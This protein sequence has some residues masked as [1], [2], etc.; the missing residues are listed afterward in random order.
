M[1]SC[2]RTCTAAVIWSLTIGTGV[3][4]AQTR[5]VR[6]ASPQTASVQP[7]VRPGT[8]RAQRV[9]V[10]FA[11]LPAVPPLATAG[12]LAP[13]LHIELF[14]GRVV[15]V[16]LDTI[17]PSGRGMAYRGAIDGDAGTFLAARAGAAFV[18]DLTLGSDRYEV[19]FDGRRHVLAL[20]DPRAVA[21]CGVDALPVAANGGAR[22][23]SVAAPIAAPVG[24]PSNIDLL[25]AFT[26]AAQAG[27][28]GAD[29]AQALAQLSV[30]AINDAFARS[31][32]PA[33]VRL[34]G[35]M[36]TATRE[37]GNYSLDVAG[38]A[39]RSDGF[40]DDVP[41]MRDA[42]A[43][44][45]VVVVAEP[46]DNRG[47]AGWAYIMAAESKADSELAY[48][49]NERDVLTFI[50]PHELGHNLGLAHD[51]ANT[52]GF[53]PFRPYAY[54]YQEPGQFY[55]IMAYPCFMC[56]PIPY[57][58]NPAVRFNG[59]PTG[60]A[61][62]ADE[63][64]AL[65]EN[66]RYVSSYRGCPL[67]VVPL[68]RFDPAASEAGGSIR[69]RID[70]P[71]GCLWQVSFTS[72]WITPPTPTGLGPTTLTLTLP[73]LAAGESTRYGSV[74]IDS[75]DFAFVQRAST[76]A[77]QDGLP[78]WW[79]SRWGFDLL[80][81]SPLYAAGGDPDGDGVTNADEYARGTHPLGF[82]TRYL[83]E[84][85]ANQFFQTRITAFNPGTTGGRAVMHFR[86]PGFPPI[87][88]FF[89]PS[90]QHADTVQPGLLP[91]VST[92]FASVIES[93][94]PL[95][96][97]RTMWWDRTGYGSHAETAI[98][99]PATTW[100][101]AEGSTSGAFSLFYLLLNP[102]PTPAT[103]TIRYLRP[104]GL[105]PIE[106]T[107]ALAPDARLTIPIDTAAPELASTDVSAV[108]TCTQAIIVERAMYLDAPGQPFAAGHESAGVTAPATRWFLAEGATGA[109]FDLFILLANPGTEAAEI[110]VDYLLPNGTTHRKHYRVPAQSR[111]TI[112]VDDEQLPAG[113]GQKPL[114]S[115]AVSSTVTSSNGVPIIVERTMWW[116]G[117]QVATP[118]WTE[119]H[120]SAGATETGTRWAL[121]EGVVGAEQATQT[122]VLIANTSPAAGGVRVTLCF[123][124]LELDANRV[125]SRTYSVPA[126]SRT[127]VDVGA[128]FPLAQHRRFGTIVESLGA[129]PAQIVVERAMYTS[130]N[131]TTWSA[132]TNVLATRLP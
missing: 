49:V 44:D 74:V 110:D 8:L 64:R 94:V 99:A 114:A 91:G 85:S 63:A 61:D 24:E 93:E 127:T 22:Q 117:P 101:L 56:Q 128:D 51:R 59:I 34:A 100:Y 80:P 30:Q 42:V 38:A 67:Q 130:Q 23:A 9:D 16:R 6:A 84:G 122:F 118:F 54:G 53:T 129:T 52:P 28:G 55:T 109:F 13:A 4:T 79:E 123:D 60:V 108:V 89:T 116:P 25:F 57:Y 37:T 18:A 98:A 92:D 50:V 14:D 75:H 121:A 27:A 88:Y 120:N 83:A 111:F 36:V 45:A 112:W 43:A 107:Y 11:A 32:V 90:S 96:V 87:D 68:D 1:S 125:V 5:L 131:G 19:R 86:Q 95:V 20:R 21:A 106:R 66:I 82:Y 3:A 105:P 26:A 15:T 62:F 104:F 46:R 2:L 77:D 102:G 12:A 69:F 103:A 97:D 47:F 70:T 40:M 71:A 124:D 115:V 17:V 81:Q 65:R 41:P 76:D 126:N 78:D 29:G 10:D 119:A 7:L 33:T 48:S 39:I 58:S 132:G 35:T 31:L 73:P 113:S 72:P